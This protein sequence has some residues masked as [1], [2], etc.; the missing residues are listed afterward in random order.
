M[1]NIFIVFVVI[2]LSAVSLL[3]MSLN[4]IQPFVIYAQNNDTIK[5]QNQSISNQITTVKILSD[6]L[7]QSLN[8]SAALLKVTSTLPEVANAKFVDKMN[9]TIRGIT[10]DVDI[11][12]RNVAN[13]ILKADDDFTSI[14]FL[15]PNGDMYMQEPYWRQLNLSQGNFAFRD[16]FKGAVETKDAF[17]AD[18][19]ESKATG[20]RQANIA[21][22]IYSNQNGSLIGVWMGPLDFSVFDRSLQSLYTSDTGRI[23]Y[24]DSKGQKISDSNTQVSKIPEQFTNL[25]SFRD[26]SSG[27]TGYNFEVVN[28]TN[29][30]IAYSPVKILSNT[31]TVLL[32]EPE[33]Q[34]Q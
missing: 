9:S 14:S 31:W 19:I 34:I 25:Q 23:V 11:A 21:V 13:A 16:Y 28:G 4:V 15:L 26:A 6:S 2:I 10:N 18:V 1:L 33:S 30:L 12:K 3:S 24:V 32:M 5:F 20:K 7:A 29:M 22:P 27:K 17:L 8:S